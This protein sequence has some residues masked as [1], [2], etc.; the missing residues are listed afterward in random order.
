MKSCLTCRIPH[1]PADE[2]L[3]VCRGVIADFVRNVGEA[4]E[5]H[6]ANYQAL[7]SVA[8]LKAAMFGLVTR[9]GKRS[10]CKTCRAT[11]YWLK[12]ASGASC[13]YT[14]EGISHFRDCKDAALFSKGKRPAQ[15]PLF[16]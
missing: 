6:A 4:A 3:D 9:L 1:D 12:H 14:A 2:C 10:N 15:A 11:I 7:A 13:P 16:S 8:A 5:K